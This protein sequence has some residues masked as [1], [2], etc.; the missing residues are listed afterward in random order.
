MIKVDVKNKGDKYLRNEGV[1]EDIVKVL[2]FLSYTSN[3][4][5]CFYSRQLVMLD[6]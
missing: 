6:C 5:C 1:V 3:S 4:L 2:L